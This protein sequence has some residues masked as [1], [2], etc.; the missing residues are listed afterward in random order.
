MYNLQSIRE[1]TL[2]QFV[3]SKAGR[4]KNRV[5]IVVDIIDDLYVLIADGDLRK[6]E[7]PKKKKIKHLSKYNLI[8]D[9]IKQRCE[10]KKKISNLMLRRE[11]DKLGPNIPNNNRRYDS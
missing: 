4:D 3:K 1:V 5:F 7:K 8:S 9:E 10:E 11:I 2:G 6:I